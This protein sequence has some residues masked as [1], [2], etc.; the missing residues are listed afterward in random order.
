MYSE[1]FLCVSCVK[2]FFERERANKRER[3]RERHQMREKETE[4]HRGKERETPRE[5]E[6]TVL[7]PKFFLTR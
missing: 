4:H 7:I 2:M 1:C 3:Q 5:R 6:Y